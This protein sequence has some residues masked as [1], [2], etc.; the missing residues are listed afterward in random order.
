MAPV[1]ESGRLRAGDLVR[2]QCQEMAHRGLGVGRLGGFVLF[3]FGALPGEDVSAR[4]T[5]VRRRHAFADTVEVHRA[6]T[7]RVSPPCP[8]FGSCGGCQLQHAAYPLQLESKREVLRG[9]LIRAGVELPEAVELRAAEQPWR[10]RWRGEFHRSQTGPPLGFKERS[11]YRVIGV[12]DCL[13]HHPTITGALAAV[14][15]ALRGGQPAVQTVQLTVGDSGG[16][17]LL[18]TRPDRSA[19]LD[20]AVAAAPRLSGMVSVTDEATSLRYRDREFRVF[21]DSF[22][23]VNQPSLGVLYETVIEFLGTTAGRH[24]VDAYGGSG[25]LS[26]RLADQGARVTVIESNPIAARLAQLHGEMYGEDRLGVVC[27]A[28]EAELPR[29]EPAAAVVLDPPRAGLGAE[30]RTWL[31]EQGPPVL[32]YLSCEV[33]ALARDLTALCRVGPYHLERLRLI[34]MFPQT[35]HF[36][37][38]VLLRRDRDRGSRAISDTEP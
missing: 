5:K 11:G 24:V 13:I 18:E 28:V 29:V 17:L 33:S 19:S 35:Y 8:Y 37:T 12:E 20:T 21:P 38:V 3:L 26:L 1:T 14:G 32:V 15:M 9:A 34:D 2:V 6:S 16:Q 31:A 23:Q 30:L 10:Y 7:Q 4:V 36:E 22:I 25:V 27:G